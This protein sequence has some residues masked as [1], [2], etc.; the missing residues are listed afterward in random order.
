VE[1]SE[2]GIAVWRAGCFRTGVDGITGCAEAGGGIAF[3]L[4]SGSFNF[5]VR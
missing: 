5:I 1:I 3:N 2:S 4:S